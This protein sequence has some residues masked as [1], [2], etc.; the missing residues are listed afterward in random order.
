MMVVRV[1]NSGSLVVASF[2][3]S[4]VTAM[5][6]R[7]DEADDA[8]SSSRLDEH[9][10]CGGSWM[11]MFARNGCPIRST[12]RCVS[13]AA[14]SSGSVNMSGFAVPVGWRETASA[15]LCR[16][17]GMCTI[18]NLY[19]SVFSFRFHSRPLEISS[20]DQSPRTF[21]N[22]LWSTATI[23]LLQPRTKKRALSRASATAR[24]SPSIGA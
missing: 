16:T 22:G 7:V 3:L 10:S 21:S 14:T 24:A 2:T 4:Q 11:R 12:G 19:R 15:A 23:R 5:V 17:P 8:S 20:R 1:D 18:R 9:E 6:L 13:V